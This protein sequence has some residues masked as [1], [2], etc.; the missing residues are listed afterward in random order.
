M[1][2]REFKSEF[3]HDLVAQALDGLDNAI[4]NA[5]ID[6]RDGFVHITRWIGS[7][8]CNRRIHSDRNRCCI[9]RES[10]W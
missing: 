6:Q 1:A 3:V 7:G 5:W 9:G 10:S 2:T 8:E 4:N